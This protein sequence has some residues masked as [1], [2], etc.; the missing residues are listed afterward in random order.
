[1]DPKKY[2]EFIK[3]RIVK[4]HS[5]FEAKFKTEKIEHDYAG[6]YCLL[7]LA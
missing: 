5:T 7:R 4:S 1:M 6:L 2:Y 3:G